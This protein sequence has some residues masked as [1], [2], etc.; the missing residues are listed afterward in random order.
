MAAA[1]DKHAEVRRCAAASLEALHQ[2]VDAAVVPA[3]VAAAT[4]EARQAL[5]RTLQVLI[6][7][8]NALHQF[9]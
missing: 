1:L 9:V 5:A 3:L 6:K 7:N 8:P 2:H 4:P